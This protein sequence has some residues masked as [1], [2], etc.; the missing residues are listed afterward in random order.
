MSTAPVRISIVNEF[1]ITFCAP[2]LLMSAPC[3][4]AKRRAAHPEQIGESR[5][6]RDDRKTETDPG[7]CFRGCVGQ[8]SD[9]NP[10][11][12]TVKVR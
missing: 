2:L 4:G 7:Q 8:M 3:D 1:P 12:Y 6:D 5:Y 11:H 9:I 10:V